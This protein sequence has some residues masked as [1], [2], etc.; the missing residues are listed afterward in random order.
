LPAAKA[1][2]AR[3][4]AEQPRHLAH[5]VHLIVVQSADGSLV[6]GDSHHYADVPGPFAPAEA[7]T[8]ILEEFAQATG[9]LPPAVLERWTGTYAV[10]DDRTYFV[11]EIAP[12]VRL[13]MITSGTGASISFGLAEATLAGLSG[14]IR[15]LAS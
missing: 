1:L 8:L 9:L 15:E 13:V 7:E 11:D 10:A 6:V 12:A 4:R 5:G 14:R 3:L 2:Q